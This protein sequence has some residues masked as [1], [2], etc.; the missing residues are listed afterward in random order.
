MNNFIIPNALQIVIDDLG[1]MNSKDDRENK[2]PSRTAMPR[3]HVA[4][5]YIAIN[6]LGKALGMR[7]NCAFVIG[8]RDPDNRLK[9]LPHFSKYGVAWDNAKYLDREELKRIV[10]VVNESEYID[11]SLHGLMHGY[12]MDGVDNWDASDFF[13]LKNKVKFQIP[14]S[15]LRARLDA[16]FGLLEYHGVK[17][18]INSYVPSSA[19]YIFN[20][21]SKILPEYGIKYVLQPFIYT[22]FYEKDTFLVT[23]ENGI[24]TTD[25]NHFIENHTSADNILPWDE[26]ESDFG[27]LPK[28]KC[29]I[30]THFPNY[31]HRDPKRNG[32]LT[33]AIATYVKSCAD[34]FG[35]MMSRDLGFYSTQALYKRF[36]KTEEKNGIFTIDVSA[37]PTPIGNLGT[38]Y[39]SAKT[40]IENC[41]GAEIAL[42]ETKATHYTYELK[43]TADIITIS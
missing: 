42:Y 22:D 36:A 31:L 19:L 23:I 35:S 14:E 12:Y 6:E 33:A 2:G 18:E 24:I 32:E 16:F 8:E 37:V 9:K 21:M 38:F 7:I 30:G 29:V 27:A 39:V 41:T 40:P 1:W 5:D 20:S 13:Y 3:N 28:S 26:C 17:K 4:E 43:P 15:E 34:D 25:R 11:I 10:E